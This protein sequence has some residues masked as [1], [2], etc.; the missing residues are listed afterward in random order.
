MRALNR[1]PCAYRFRTGADLQGHHCRRG[2]SRARRYDL[3]SLSLLIVDDHV[4]FRG[5]AI[6]LFEAQGFAVAGAAGDG[7]SALKQV[8]RLRPD[9]VLVDV[10]LPGIDGFE[11]ASRLSRRSVPP[12]VVLTS[13][14]EAADYGERLRAAPVLG[15]IPKRALSGPALAA[16]VGEG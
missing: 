3:M 13:S 15:F 16:L 6:S 2:A 1:G 10:Q 7:E 8:E 12:R 14:R 4:A 9:V 5:F 11:V